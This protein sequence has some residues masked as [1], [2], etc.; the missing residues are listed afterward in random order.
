[1]NATT[2]S[3][4]VDGAIGFSIIVAAVVLLA[5][6]KIDGKT[7]IALI[8]AGAALASGSGKAALALRVPAPTQSVAPPNVSVT[9]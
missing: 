5:L 8:G 3:I 6:A 2:V 9:Q 1:M 4:I 7:G